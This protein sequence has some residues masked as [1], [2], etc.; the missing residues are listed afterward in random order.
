MQ[1]RKS[2]GGLIVKNISVYN[3]LIAV[4]SGAAYFIGINGI[5]PTV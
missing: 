5:V 2:F 4:S 3:K 1:I